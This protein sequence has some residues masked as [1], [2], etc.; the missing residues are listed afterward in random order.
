MLAIFAIAFYINMVPLFGGG[1]GMEAVYIQ[2]F[3]FF[4]LFYTSIYWLEEVGH[5]QTLIFSMV[6][7][8][9]S[10]L[11]AKTAPDT[12]GES[13]NREAV[14]EILSS[15]GQVYL[16]NGLTKFTGCWFSIKE[17]SIATGTILVAGLLGQYTPTFIKYT[18]IE[19]LRKDPFQPDKKD[20]TKILDEFKLV[21]FL[22]N[23]VLTVL[24]MV[25][26]ESKPRDYPTLSQQYYRSKMYEPHLDVKYLLQYKEFKIF[27]VT[28]SFLLAAVNVVPS[29][30]I[31]FAIGA[32]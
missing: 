18:Y 25:K 16:F 26:F 3:A 27:A 23:V 24:I 31:Q 15:I 17:R 14:A 10:V 20:L 2:Y 7:Q 30:A 28:C 29:V 19:S 6:F 5:Y 22:I 9:L 11:I 32:F 13:S 4:P 1:G 12:T 8:T 21:L